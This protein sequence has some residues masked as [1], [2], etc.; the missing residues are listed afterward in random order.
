MH[1]SKNVGS[2]SETHVRENTDWSLHGVYFHAPRNKDF[3]EEIWKPYA[4]FCQGSKR[5]GQA[6]VHLSTTHW[7]LNSVQGLHEISKK[8]SVRCERRRHQAGVFLSQWDNWTNPLPKTRESKIPQPLVFKK[9]MQRVRS[10]EAV[11]DAGRKRWQWQWGNK[12]VFATFN[13]MQMKHDY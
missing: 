12:K 13:E 3:P 10:P 6:D 4:T 7:D 9:R 5:M 11:I 8:K 1:R 2:T